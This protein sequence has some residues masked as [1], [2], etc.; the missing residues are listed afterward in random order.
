[1]LLLLDV[2]NVV[3]ESVVKAN[4]C[5]SLVFLPQIRQCRREVS[6]RKKLAVD[7][8]YLVLYFYPRHIANS[9][10]THGT[11]IMN[12]TVNFSYQF[13]KKK[14]GIF[15]QFLFDDQIKSRLAKDARAFKVCTVLE[16]Q[17]ILR[18]DFQDCMQYKFFTF[19]KT[20]H[21]CNLSELPS[22]QI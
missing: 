6:I 4:S 10:R 21:N 14:F 15:S 18:L 17:S 7:S 19:L 9:I 1:M 11:G 22:N 2:G 13:L 16:F 5:K 12:T 3:S 20:Y 8:I